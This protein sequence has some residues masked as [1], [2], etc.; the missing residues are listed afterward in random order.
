M[1][2][3]KAQV[4][5]ASCDIQSSTSSKPRAGK[6]SSREALA[7]SQCRAQLPSPL[8]SS[9]DILGTPSS[10]WI[11]ADSFPSSVSSSHAREWL[12]ETTRGLQ[13]HPSFAKEWIFIGSPWISR[14][15]DNATLP[16]EQILL[17][18]EE[19]FYFIL[20]LEQST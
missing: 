16:L 13:E 10:T 6:S 8:V 12:L 5:K 17:Q 2:V 4:Q 7:G 15:S 19:Q 20:Y 9:A 1:A 18:K 3:R 11:C 14:F